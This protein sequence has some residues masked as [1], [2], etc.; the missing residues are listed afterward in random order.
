M[1]PKYLPDSE[2]CK[3]ARL[4]REKVCKRA[5]IKAGKRININRGARFGTECSL[6]DHSGIGRDSVIQNGTTIG[7]NVMMGPQCY[8]YTM[9]HVFARADIP[10][11]QQGISRINPVVIGDDVWIG[12]RV[13][14]LG[15]VHVGNGAIIGAGAVVTQDVLSYAIVAGNPARVIRM[16]NV[17]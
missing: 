6:G 2:H 1:L 3:V 12:A 17:T 8:I 10:M 15:G 4:I 5:L 7:D 14:I 9:N 11:I 16:R 13:T